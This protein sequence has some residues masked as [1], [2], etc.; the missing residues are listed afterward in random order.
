[1]AYT[2]SKDF[3]PAHD[4]LL[5]TMVDAGGWKGN[6]LGHIVQ[7]PDRLKNQKAKVRRLKGQKI[8]SN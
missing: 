8:K 7:K 4:H 3:P 2:I 5:E 6:F 1:M